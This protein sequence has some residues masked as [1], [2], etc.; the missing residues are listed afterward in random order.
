MWRAL[1]T[2]ATVDPRPE[3]MDFEHLVARAELQRSKVRLEI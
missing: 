2:L 1:T 3:G